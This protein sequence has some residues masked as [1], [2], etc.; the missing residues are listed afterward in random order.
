[1]KVAFSLVASF[2]LAGSEVAAQGWLSV[3]GKEV[4]DEGW[5]RDLEKGI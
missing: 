5:G 4:E 2:S 3:G 1:M